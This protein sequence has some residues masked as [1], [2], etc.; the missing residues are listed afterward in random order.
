MYYFQM[1][2]QKVYI[3]RENV[4]QLNNLNKFATGVAAIAHFLHQF[5]SRLISQL[6]K[7]I[8]GVLQ[9]LLRY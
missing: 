7:G 9:K 8:S 5:R 6:I 3:L 1:I 2:K 4:N